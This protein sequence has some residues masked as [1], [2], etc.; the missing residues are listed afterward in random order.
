MAWP[1]TARA[2]YANAAAEG[3]YRQAMDRLG[4]LGRSLEAGL[5]IFRRLGARK[6]AERVEQIIADGQQT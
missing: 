4:A 2:Q 6:D 1:T 5:A 3:S